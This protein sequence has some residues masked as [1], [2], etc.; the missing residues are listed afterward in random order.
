MQEVFYSVPD[1]ANSLHVDTETVYRWL[2]SG[3]LRG[4][5]LGESIWRVSQK[6]MDEFT[7]PNNSKME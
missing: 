4:T 1:I 6:D 5:K 3:K 2:R 7:K